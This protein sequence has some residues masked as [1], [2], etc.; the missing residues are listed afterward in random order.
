MSMTT[1]MNKVKLL[2]LDYSVDQFETELIESCVATEIEKLSLHITHEGSFPKDLFSQGFT[3]IIHSGSSLSINDSAPFTKQAV[4]LIRWAKHH[5]LWQMGICY[6][7]Q[8]LALALV[9]KHAVQ[10]SSNGF[11]AGWRTVH[12]SKEAQRLF[13]IQEVEKVWQH[14]F[15]EVIQCP[16]GSEIL[17][18]NNHSFIQAYIN[19]EQRLLGTQFHPEFDQNK[20]NAFFRKDRKLLEKNHFNLAEILADGPGFDSRK[21]VFGF[22]LNN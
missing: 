6:G 5:H 10:A 1:L 12:F 21:V 22:F 9:G 20:G 16:E 15:D 4:E 19:Y 18:S 11:E 14:H 17:A 13:N 3:H 2:I 7:H 8:L